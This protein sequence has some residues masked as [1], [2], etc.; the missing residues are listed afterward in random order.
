MPGRAL[1][2]LVV[3]DDEEDFFILRDLL[4]DHG[5]PHEVHWVPTLAQGMQALRD[6]TYDVYLVDYRLGPDNG[7]DLVR[8]AETCSARRPV[9]LLTGKGNTE[10]D[11]QALEAGAADY[12]VKGHISPDALARSVR[13]AAERSRQR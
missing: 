1:R 6:A 11:H 12:L 8:F 10:V 5:E 3:D 2:L 4:A 7:L 13:Y 9:I